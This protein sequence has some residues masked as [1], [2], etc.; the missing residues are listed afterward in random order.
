MKS[1][2]RLNLITTGLNAN[3]PAVKASIVFAM[4]FGSNRFIA[5]LRSV[6]SNNTITS[7]L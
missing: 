5:L 4:I 3:T 6:N 1:I 2:A 7:S